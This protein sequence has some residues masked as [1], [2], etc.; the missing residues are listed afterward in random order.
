MSSILLLFILMA[1]A[2]IAARPTA[3]TPSA[4]TMSQS[5]Q[6]DESITSAKNQNKRVFALYVVILVVAALAA[7]FM[8]VWLWKSGNKVQNTIQAVASARILAANALS[9]EAKAEAAAAN[10]RTQHLER[11]TADAKAAQQRVET[12]LAKQREKT[13]R[14]EIE[15]ASLSEAIRPRRL[16]QEQEK[17]LIRLLSG[18]PRGPVTILCPAND[19]ESG[20]FAGQITGALRSAGWAAQR[21]DVV[22]GGG[23]PVG[24]G[25]VVHSFITAPP[26]VARIQGAFF[27]VGIAPGGI[28]DP[29]LPEREVQIVVGHKPAPPNSESQ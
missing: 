7:A 20:A 24:F 13:A 9:E 22:Y 3:N 21:A 25:I 29:K 15:L 27:S 17:A 28:E 11:E 12:E 14:A 10:E 26:Y 16:T 4:P 1:N 8:T 5:S 23:G 18:E 6:D 19:A 2:P